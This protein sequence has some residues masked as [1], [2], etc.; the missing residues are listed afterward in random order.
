MK[1]FVININFRYNYRMQLKASLH[2]HTSEDKKDG[3]IINYNVYNLIDE[4]A[5]SG[6]NVLGFTPHNK[7][8]F[9]E[10]F[11]EYAKKKGILLIPGVERGLGRFFNK[12]VIILN[13]DKTIEK[14]KTL[15]QLLKYK[16]EHSEIF[17]L[18]PHPTYNR[19]I[20]IGARKLKKYIDLFDAIEYS[21]AYS[22]KL[23]FH[24][25]RA[26]K[27]ADSFK[28][29]IISTADVHVLKKLNTDYALIE[30]VD[31][32]TESVLQAIKYGKFINITAP[33][34]FFALMKY[35]INFLI[36]Y[37][38]KYITVKILGLRIRELEL[39]AVKERV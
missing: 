24:N 21:A 14:V 38:V 23:N 15:E 12:H 13:C 25:K 20:S 1:L 7:F 34:N 32:T 33:K 30:A 27:I 9:K 3:H 2:I 28:K 6:F 39:E 16:V 10:E 31:L 26:Q 17:I 4:A 29:P 36:K 18:A 35:Y 8:V 5:K 22:K 19:L 37:I 11:A